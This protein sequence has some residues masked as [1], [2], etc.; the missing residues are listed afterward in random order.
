MKAADIMSRHVIS[1][2]PDAPVE[3]AA[4]LMLDHRIGGLPVCAPDGRLVGI[5]S[6]SDLLRRAEAGTEKRRPHWLEFVLGPGKLAGEYAHSHSRLVADVMTPAPVTVA[7]NDSL[8]HVVGLMERKRIHRL[9]VLEAGRLAGIVT[10][11]DLMR[12]LLSAAHRIPAG[13]ASDEQIRQQ[14]WAELARQPWATPG[15][16][17]VLVQDGVVTLGG[18][19]PDPRQIDALRV[20]AANLPGVRAVRDDMVWCDYLSGAVVDMSDR[21]KASGPAGAP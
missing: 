6:D 7:P 4:Q 16:V 8:E 19:V 15:M 13:P 20:L 10:R 18:G 17:Q 12:A 14:L 1:V 11:A 3:Q 9:P 5:V 21:P 2:P